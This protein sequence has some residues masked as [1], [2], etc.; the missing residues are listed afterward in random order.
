MLKLSE[1]LVQLL[2]IYKNKASRCENN[3]YLYSS[4]LA[5]SSSVC[6]FA[7]PEA[8]FDCALNSTLLDLS[9]LLVE[10]GRFLT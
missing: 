5:K 2:Y 3:S 9:A 4:S 8:D 7:W 6:F 1:G 10:D